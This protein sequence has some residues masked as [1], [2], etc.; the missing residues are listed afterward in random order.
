ML[1]KV[2]IRDRHI[3]LKFNTVDGDLKTRDGKKPDSFEIAGPDR[4]F[5]PASAIVRKDRVQLTSPEIEHP[6]AVRFGWDETA[7]PNLV[8]ATGLPVAPF[9]TDNWPIQNEKTTP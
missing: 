9:R 5:H 4:V 8:S 6:V 1:E 7:N 2:T 3:I